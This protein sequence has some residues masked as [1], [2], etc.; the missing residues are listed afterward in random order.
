[1]RPLSHTGLLEKVDGGSTWAV[2]DDYQLATN[3]SA[4][5]IK[6]FIAPNGTVYAV[7]GAVDSS[8]SQHWIVRKSTNNGATWTTA[9]DYRY[10]S[11]AS[12][13]NDIGV[14]SMGNIYVVGD[15]S[16]A[17]FWIVRKSTD[18]GITWTTI[19]TFQYPPGIATVPF[20]FTADGLNNFYAQDMGLML[21]LLEKCLLGKVLMV[22]PPGQQ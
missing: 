9:D 12:A 7:G 8:D 21:L 2:I 15:G 4:G 16:N 19:D 13:A 17:T 14:D 10:L 6:V 1:M 5:A 22:V 3:E 20:S 11:T 18:S